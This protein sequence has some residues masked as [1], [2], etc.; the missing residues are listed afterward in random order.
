MKGPW[1][2]LSITTAINSSLR[3]RLLFDLD[4]IESSHEQYL[5]ELRHPDSAFCT[6]L[7]KEYP[8]ETLPFYFVAIVGIF[9]LLDNC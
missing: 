9:R 2:P 8:P 4:T 1:W 3:K 7:R 6:V 5:S